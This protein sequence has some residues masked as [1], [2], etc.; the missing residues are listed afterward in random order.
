MAKAVI[1]KNWYEIQ[2]PDIFSE[3][4][5]GETPAEKESQVI[6]RRVSRDLTELMEG[7]SKYYVDVSLKITDVEG[8]KAFTE[9]DGM[10]CSK[11]FVSR[12]IRK[13]SDRLDL[14]H[15]TETKDGRTVRVK[16]VG[17]TVNNT[18][19]QTLNAAR[20]KI[21]EVIDD[22]A[23]DMEYHELMESIFKDDLQEDIRDQTNQIYPF[24]EL[25]VRKTELL[26]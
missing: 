18:S 22:N 10:E 2:A 4:A 23:S 12:M 24:R 9:I 21:K 25:E 26:D 20:N 3:D 16:V 15:D 8:N 1:Q 17:A 7:T 6:G 5:V 19:S 11:E 14:V 13:R